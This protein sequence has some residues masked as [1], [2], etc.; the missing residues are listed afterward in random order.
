MPPVAYPVDRTPGGAIPGAV[1]GDVNGDGKDDIVVW[2]SNSS[3]FSILYGNG[4]GTFQD[5]VPVDFS[6][7][8]NVQS[9]VLAP[10]NGRLDLVTGGGL[11][12]AIIKVFVNQGNDGD[13]HAQFLQGPA[14]DYIVPDT[15]IYGLGVG[16]F[17]GD[18]I[19]DVIFASANTRYVGVFRGVP[20][21]TLAGPPIFT[22]AQYGGGG[23]GYLAIGDFD[24]DG[25]LDVAVTGRSYDNLGH[26]SVL[27]GNGDG[28][29]LA[30]S[31]YAVRDSAWAV[32][33]GDF[34]GDGSPDLAAA[35][36][37]DGVGILLN[38]VGRAP[39]P[40]PAP[41]PGLSAGDLVA[42]GGNG[43]M[44]TLAALPPVSPTSEEGSP[45]SGTRAIAPV[46]RFFAVLGQ[47]ASG[48]A[49]WRWRPRPV[50]WLDEVPPWEALIE[51][52]SEAGEILSAK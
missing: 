38:A 36:H 12:S 18:G 47:Q 51:D 9:M 21:G 33:V 42:F 6:G 13:G 37:D 28:H 23:D 30:P 3:T 8:G 24:G 44:G 22:F 14:N 10:L 16:D 20:D 4:D 15:D 43:G 40:A 39:V 45:A 49:V 32:A 52:Y 27:F 25:K 19:P 11:P 2:N 26:V 5:A 34:N 48:V 29:F 1:V 31:I 7:P 50:P 46:D 41:L 17:T 35:V